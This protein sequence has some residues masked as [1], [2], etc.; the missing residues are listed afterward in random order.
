MSKLTDIITRVM[1]KGE[2]TSEHAA[3]ESASSFGRILTVIGS[4]SAMLP[5]ILELANML[6]E[7]AKNSKWGATGFAVIGG[8]IAVLG[9]F[10]ETTAKVAYINGRSLIKAAAIRDVPPGTEV[11]AET[12]TPA[13]PPM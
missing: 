3:M 11:P 13:T 2:T 4:V 5:Q 1:A 8:I 7:S 12:T 6:P 10:K 9:V